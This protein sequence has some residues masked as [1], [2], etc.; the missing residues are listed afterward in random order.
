ML[1]NVDQKHCYYCVNKPKEVD[2][3]DIQILQRFL[4]HYARIVPHRRT[5]LCAKHQRKVAKAIKQARI[6]GLMPFIKS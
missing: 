4:S 5:G 2:F 3:R 1:N 6:M